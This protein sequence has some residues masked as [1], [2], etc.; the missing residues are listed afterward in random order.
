MAPASKAPSK[1]LRVLPA[2]IL[3][4]NTDTEPKYT[5]PETLMF[6]SKVAF[7]FLM[8]TSTVSVGY[9]HT[10]TFRCLHPPTNPSVPTPSA[11]PASNT[12]AG[13]LMVLTTHDPNFQ[14]N[15]KETGKAGKGAQ[16]QA[17]LSWRDD[18]PESHVRGVR[19]AHRQVLVWCELALRQRCQ[20]V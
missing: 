5:C 10:A 11:S 9:Y 2:S 6:V 8:D 18:I 14:P 3:R 16:R 7:E 12:T 19:K 20:A 4:M 13:V 15:T 1:I 17:L